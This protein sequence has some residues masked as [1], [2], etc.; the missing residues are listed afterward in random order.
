M[1]STAQRRPPD[2]FSEQTTDV[3]GLKINYVRGGDGPTLVLLHGYPQ[4]WYMW[5]KVMPELAE[6]YTV[7]A[8][9]MRGAGDSDAPAD[10]YDKKT[11]AGDLHG[12]LGR[13]DLDDS[14]RLIGHDIGAMVAYSYA[15]QHPDDV[16]R[17]VF[18]EAVIPDEAIYR[19][20]V[21]TSHG[22]GHWNFG[23][24]NV[25]SGF[26]EGL[27]EGRELAWVTG[28]MKPQAVRPEGIDD[29]SLREWA[30]CLTDAAH[31]RASFAYFR[32]LSHDM[33][34]NAEFVK[35][36]L[37]M[38]VLAIGAADS[39]GDSVGEQLAGYAQ[40]VHVGVIDDAGHYVF[41]EQP[42]ELSRMVLDFLK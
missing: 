8:P 26:P 21:L 25:G 13:L 1:G 27:V 41:E 23:L 15:A 10:G 12:L 40:D 38:P 39:L 6:S 11:L 4:T 31:L 5:R 7:V 14:V 2:G 34:D 24:F 18:A 35:N 30:R 3:G 32:E 28:F 17:M 33:V 16:E 9:D 36:R 19:M 37:P 20:P 22:P 42:E 29:E